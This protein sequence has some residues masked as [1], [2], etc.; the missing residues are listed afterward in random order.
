MEG[1]EETEETIK[2]ERRKFSQYNTMQCDRIR[3]GTVRYDTIRYDTVWYDTIRYG[4]VQ[5]D[6]VRYDKMEKLEVED[7]SSGSQLILLFQN[8]T[9]RK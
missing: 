8:D 5:Y 6:T 7:C 3:Y 4:T 2:L 9:E 1:N